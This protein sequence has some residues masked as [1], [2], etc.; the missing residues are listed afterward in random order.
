MEDIVKSN[1]TSKSKVATK[2]PRSAN[3][4]V[5]RNASRQREG[6]KQQAVLGLLRRPEGTTVAAV[7][8]I[9]KWQQHSV[10]GFLSGVVRKKL[11][12]NL[13]SEKKDGDRT[14]RIIAAGSA[15]SRSKARH[16]PRS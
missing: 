8:K 3:T 15:P 12:L 6:S 2:Q 5:V 4:E 13:V 1:K 7:M 9:T 14:Y 10:H 11:G 16:Q